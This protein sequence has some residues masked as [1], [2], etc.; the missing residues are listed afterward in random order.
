MADLCN[1]LKF[2]GRVG[3]ANGCCIECIILVT[4][5][6]EQIFVFYG[7]F[8]SSFDSFQLGKERGSLK[9]FKIYNISILFSGDPGKARAALQTP[10]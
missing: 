1:C 8:F 2:G 3:A 7:T 6:S 4:H 5:T 10:P 9:S